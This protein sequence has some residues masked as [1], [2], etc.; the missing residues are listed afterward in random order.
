MKKYYPELRSLIVTLLLI[1]G[2]H[3]YQL[4]LHKNLEPP[5]KV[6]V[7]NAAQLVDNYSRELLAK[8][9]NP[10]EHQEELTQKFSKYFEQLF[11]FATAKQQ[12]NYIILRPEAFEA[13]G[14]ERYIDL[15]I[16]FNAQL[17]AE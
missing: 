9:E 3:C 2:Y 10:A 7:F 16:E 11:A 17:T 14:K 6:A 4:H 1:G 5:V 15:A 12:E 13:V 8:Y